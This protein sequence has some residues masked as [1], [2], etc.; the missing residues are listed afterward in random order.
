LFN[1]IGGNAKDYR[2]RAVNAD[3]AGE[4]GIAGEQVELHGI[5]PDAAESRDQAFED[6][7]ASALDSG[8]RA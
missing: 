8:G 6:L 1:F 2:I 7:A 3:P 4:A 5:A